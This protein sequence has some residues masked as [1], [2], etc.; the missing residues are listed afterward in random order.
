MLGRREAMYRRLLLRLQLRDGLDRAE[1][2]ADF[3]EDPRVAFGNLLPQLEVL[4]CVEQTPTAVRVTRSGGFFVEDVCDRVVDAA[5]REQ[6]GDHLRHSH[7]E[8]S[9]DW[10]LGG[11][12]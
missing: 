12:G 3:G 1:F 4:G 2:Q 9:A 6:A 8:G 10:R 11:R 5:M 7:S